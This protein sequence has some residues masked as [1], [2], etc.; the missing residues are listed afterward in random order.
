M[1]TNIYYCLPPAGGRIRSKGNKMRR[2]RRRTR[3]G[4]EVCVF[5]TAGPVIKLFAGGEEESGGHV[6]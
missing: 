4:V 5:I 1:D 2:P 3:E 6:L